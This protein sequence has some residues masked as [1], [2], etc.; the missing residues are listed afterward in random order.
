LNTKNYFIIFSLPA[1]GGGVFC[2]IINHLLFYPRQKRG[3][4]FIIKMKIL[5]IGEIVLDEIFLLDRFPKEEEK[6]EASDVILSVGGSAFTACLFLSKFDTNQ[7][8]FVGGLAK[9]KTGYEIRNLLRNEKIELIISPQ[10]KTPKNMVLVN[11]QSGNRTIIKDKIKTREI[12][13]LEKKLIKEADL[14]ILDRHQ[15]QIFDQILTHKKRTTSVIFDPSTEFS[16]RTLRIL[17]QVD[18]PIIPIEFLKNFNYEKKINNLEEKNFQLAQILKKNIIII[19]A[20]KNG[21][22]LWK[23]KQ[24]KHYPSWQVP[25]IDTLGAGD[26]FRGGF[27]QAILEGKNLEEAINFAN[28]C[29]AL[30]C[31]KIGSGIAVPSKKEIERLFSNAKKNKTNLTL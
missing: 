28:F 21:C 2:S 5:G 27:A 13:F 29:A 4:F 22:F 20:G 3:I 1:A 30:Q 12:V 8:K 18:Y 9:D 6:I 10:A 26:V 19:T 31:T 7:V 11:R 16:P 14:I 17:K 23:D 24:L 25:V 15:T